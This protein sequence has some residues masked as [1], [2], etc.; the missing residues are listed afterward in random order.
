MIKVRLASMLLCF[1]LVPAIGFSQGHMLHGVGAVNS[2]MG[3]AGVALMIESL[4]A[5][6]FNPA[7]ITEG[8]GN[9]VSFSTEFFKDG[10]RV[11]TRVGT[12]Q[13]Q[14][15][16]LL[17]VG[18]VPAFGWTMRAPTGRMAIGFGLLGVAGFR[19]DY[20]QDNNNVLMLRQPVGFGRIATDY[21]LTKI[22]VAMAFQVNPRLSI[23]ASLNVYRGTL[24]IIPLPVT[25]PDY[26]TSG[27]PYLPW[28]A[29]PVSRFGLGGQFG[30]AYKA[31]DMVTIGAS[32]QTYATFKRYEWSS[33][34][35]NPT[36]SSFGLARTIGIQWDA[37]S[38]FTFGVG[39]HPSKRTQV[40][41]DGQ[42]TKYD[43]VEGLGG[44]GGV[45]TVA[46][47]L[48]GVGWRNIWT[49]KA[50]VQHRVSD[51]MVVRAGYNHSQTPIR[52]D[53]V[54]TSMGTPAT[55]Q[56][57]FTAGVGMQLAPHV[58]ADMG[59]YVVPREH[60][61]GPILSLQTGTVPDS[62]LDM[63]NRITSFQMA[64]NFKF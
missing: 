46:K 22:P 63:S 27:Q 4:G 61:R 7:L 5:L 12:L 44:P 51:T 62:S 41:I 54:E 48:V 15:N 17:Q 33:S 11:D 50:G 47:K 8:E 32:Y 58:T 1:G 38:M 45:D 64:L 9:Q 57:H 25:T 55:F 3:G 53:I 59:F 20:P 56:K 60:V 26:D 37:P 6:A 40:A 23:G 10:L 24:V 18:V 13:Q 43:N 21:Q 2:S 16:P 52:A 30:L 14:I 28:A 36:S 49:F 34:N 39:L 42:M 35:N 31:S 29:N 19:T